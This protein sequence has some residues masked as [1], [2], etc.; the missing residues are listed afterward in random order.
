MLEE[1]WPNG[2]M[3]GPHVV[4]RLGDPEV[5]AFVRERLAELRWQQLLALTE[6]APPRTE[7]HEESK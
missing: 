2:P 3:G 4:G 7:S 6:A 5:V 1:S